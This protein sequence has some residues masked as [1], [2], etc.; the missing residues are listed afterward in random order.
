[1]TES[2][3]WWLAWFTVNYGGAYHIIIEEDWW[4]AVRADNAEVLTADTAEELR[5]KMRADY[6][7]RPVL[8]KDDEH[9]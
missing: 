1:M 4:G 5:D 8:R 2:D 7:E 9:E 3:A 6:A